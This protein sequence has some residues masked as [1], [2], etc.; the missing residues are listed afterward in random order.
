MFFSF[1]TSPSNYGGHYNSVFIYIMANQHFIIISIC[2]ILFSIRTI[3]GY[4]HPYQ[5]NKII[6]LT[7]LS[8]LLISNINSLQKLHSFDALHRMTTTKY[9]VIYDF[10]SYV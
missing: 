4:L 8:V 1:H 3:N 6:T 9:I 7:A 5:L 10:K 2:F